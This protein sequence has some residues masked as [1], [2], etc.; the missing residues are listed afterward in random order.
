LV[1]ILDADKE[2]FLRS[3]RSLIQTC[4]RAARNVFGTVI[5]YADHVTRS[6]QRAV[7]EM[8]R[9]R[10]LQE[11]YN[12]R[13]HITPES[14]QKEI[15]S[16]LTSVY[17]ADYVTVPTVSEP[18]AEYRSVDDLEKVI[19]ELEEEMKK[20]VRELAFE[21]AAQLRDEIKELRKLDMDLR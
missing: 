20:A 2:G 12:K 7:D 11:A 21:K 9:R 13:Y 5:L 1:A 19:K 8:N 15:T 10:R 17:E 14:I 16:I 3:E 18:S 4:G 6:M